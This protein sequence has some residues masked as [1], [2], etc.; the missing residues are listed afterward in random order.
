MVAYR[1][2]LWKIPFVGYCNLF[3]NTKR[4]L[5][6][7][8]APYLIWS[9]RSISVRVESGQFCTN[10]H[11]Y[12]ERDAAQPS[13]RAVLESTFYAILSINTGLHIVSM[14]SVFTAMLMHIR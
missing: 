1:S 11:V 9:G 14:E 6:D 4:I 3:G 2:I 7:I 12:R 10:H 8:S 13:K 5:Q